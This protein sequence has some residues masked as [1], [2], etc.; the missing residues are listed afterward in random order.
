MNRQRNAYDTAGDRKNQ[1]SP[2]HALPNSGIPTPTEDP[3]EAIR[4]EIL[5]SH[6]QAAQKRRKRRSGSGPE[7]A[8]GL[9]VTVKDKVKKLFERSE[10]GH[11]PTPRG[12][13]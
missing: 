13:G 7:P 6:R 11:K 3:M 9:A 8:S 10:S 12:V 1:A 2:E 5:D 4:R